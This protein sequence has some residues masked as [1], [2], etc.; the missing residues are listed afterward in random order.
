MEQTPKI[1]ICPICGEGGRTV[2][3][4]DNFTSAGALCRDQS[5]PKFLL[6]HCKCGNSWVEKTGKAQKPTRKEK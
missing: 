6:V 5:S 2:A 3:C 1:Y 4:S